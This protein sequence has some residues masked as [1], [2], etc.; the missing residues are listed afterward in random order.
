MKKNELLE[1]IDMAND[2]EEQMITN[3]AGHIEAALEWF[4]GTPE[5]REKLRDVLI[6]LKVE[7]KK[8]AHLLTCL[9]KHVQKKG[10][11]VY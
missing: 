7:S 11:D 9:K 3:L 10:K 1:L 6:R 8:H 2:A 4:K 5:E